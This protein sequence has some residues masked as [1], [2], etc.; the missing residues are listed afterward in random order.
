MFI[1]I[2]F[3]P[4]AGSTFIKELGGVYK[5]YHGYV[6][7]VVSTSGVDPGSGLYI[8]DFMYNLFVFN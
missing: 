5:G 7:A 4:I 8:T 2:L 6:A 3:S 1:N